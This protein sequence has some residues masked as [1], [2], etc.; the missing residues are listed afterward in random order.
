MIQD[1]SKEYI[2]MSQGISR[3]VL[4]IVAVG[5]VAAAGCERGF[6]DDALRT[7]LARFLTDVVTTAVNATITPQT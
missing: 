1:S 6:I 5:A 3:V 7:N 2:K 4:W